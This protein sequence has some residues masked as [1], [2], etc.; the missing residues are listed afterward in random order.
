MRLGSKQQLAAAE[1]RALEAASGLELQLADQRAQ[2][3]AAEEQVS[4][5]RQA[6]E[7]VERAARDAAGDGAQS[8]RELQAVRAEL[9]RA[10]AAE[11][12]C[13]ALVYVRVVG[14]REAAGVGGVAVVYPCCVLHDAG[15]C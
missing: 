1:A 9:A 6:L 11:V 14:R 3:R 7:A 4:A 13:V 2:A 10:K 12:R 15:G 8:Q 5:L